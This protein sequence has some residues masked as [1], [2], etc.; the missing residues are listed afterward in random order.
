MTKEN[1]T[2]KIKNPQLPWY[3][4]IGV[5]MSEIKSYIKDI[6]LYPIALWHGGHYWNDLYLW[7]IH[8]CGMREEN[9]SLKSKDGIGGLPEKLYNC[10]LSW[11]W[12][13]RS[14]SAESTW[15]A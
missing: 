10:G 7:N 11:I 14:G 3:L 4:S 15:D 6:S 2:E 8:V 1:V 9:C 5:D 13:E 12:E